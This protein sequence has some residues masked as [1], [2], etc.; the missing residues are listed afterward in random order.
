M[1]DAAAEAGTDGAVR[2]AS[3]DFSG[4]NVQVF[5]VDEPDIVKT[6]GERIVSL[7][8]GRLVVVDVTGDEPE[9]VGR[10]N[11]GNRSIQSIF[12]SGDT[13]L[14]FGSAW[15][16]FHPLVESDV[17]LAPTYQTPTIQLLEVDISDEPEIVRTMTIDGRFLSGR[18]V[19]DSVR[20]VM[21]SSPGR[22][23]VELSDRLRSACRAQGDRGEP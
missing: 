9:L 13:V 21:T 4:T 7:T 19:E 5:G 2:S 23:R 8:E 18:M 20:L 3:S 16:T 12:L 11:L 10:L 22:L 17:E 14:L 1:D 6:D 15:S